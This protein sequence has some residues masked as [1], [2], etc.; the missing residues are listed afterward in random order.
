[1]GAG[2]AVFDNLNARISNTKWRLNRGV[3]E[4]RSRN[5]MYLHGAPYAYTY[6]PLTKTGTIGGIKDRNG[7]EWNHIGLFSIT[8]DSITFTNYKES[9]LTVTYTKEPAGGGTANEA[10]LVGTDWWWDG[11][12]L[13]LEFI[14]DTT[15]LLWSNTGYYEIPILFDYT[16]NAG[17]KTGRVYNGRNAIG[18]KY[19][20]GDYSIS[21]TGKTLSFTQYGPYPHGADFVKQE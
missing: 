1:M 15:T 7:R 8:G 17:T 10:S 4:F 9:G 16:F 2:R 11:T 3:M 6:D 13:H 5:E 18:T 21:A 12:S 19:D 20:L 14:N